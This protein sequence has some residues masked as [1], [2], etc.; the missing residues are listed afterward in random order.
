MAMTL[1]EIEARV[2]QTSS[3]DFA[4]R[5]EH[6]FLVWEDSGSLDIDA[7]FQTSGLNLDPAQIEQDTYRDWLVFEVRKSDRNTFK[8]MVTIGRTDNND[9]VVKESSVSKFHAYISQDLKGTGFKLTDAGSRNGTTMA[10]VNVLA[11]QSS[12]LHSG[13]RLTFG[14]VSMRFF[15]ARDLCSFL[16]QKRKEAL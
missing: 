7:G 15:T 2:L 4:S 3:D 6:G 5:N 1:G 12:E 16:A 10:G 13:V 8:N 9:V 14:R 11:H